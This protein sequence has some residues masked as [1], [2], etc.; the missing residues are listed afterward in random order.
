MTPAELLA[1]VQAWQR[2]RPTWLAEVRA[3][4]LVPEHLPQFG[5]PLDVI[6]RDALVAEVMGTEP[7]PVIIPVLKKRRRF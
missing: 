1:E 5:P 7:P 2:E 6:T 4:R 3:A